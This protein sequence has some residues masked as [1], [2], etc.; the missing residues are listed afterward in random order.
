MKDI[1]IKLEVFWI[2]QSK[3]KKFIYIFL[4]LIILYSIVM[5][6]YWLPIT[7]IVV[8]PE[9]LALFSR[10]SVAMWAASD[11]SNIV[12][13]ITVDKDGNL[14]LTFAKPYLRDAINDLKDI[15]DM[16]EREEEIVYNEDYTQI[17]IDPNKP[18]EW[19]ER[20]VAWGVF[21]CMLYQLY[22]GVEPTDIS[23]DFQVVNPETGEVMYQANH[24]QENIEFTYYTKDGPVTFEMTKGYDVLIT[25]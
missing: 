3:F 7:K 18:I 21:E 5:S 12:D 9:E 8:S 24:P 6:L 22:N 20:Y 19:S 17:I 2:R 1:I 14:V 4:L 10:H 13:I 23:V 15:L 11:D 16:H 25:E